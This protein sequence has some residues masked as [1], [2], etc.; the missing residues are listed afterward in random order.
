MLKQDS[1]PFST[2]PNSQPTVG[3][4]AVEDVTRLLASVSLTAATAQRPA[5]QEVRTRVHLCS[6]C[7]FF[8]FFL[9]KLFPR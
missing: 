2:Q 1:F 5:E 6:V 8:L 3:G 7:S 9:F 4:E